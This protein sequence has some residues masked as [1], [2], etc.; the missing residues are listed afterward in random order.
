[1][2]WFFLPPEGRETH[3]IPPIYEHAATMA[4]DTFGDEDA[5]Q[6]YI[7]RILA[8]IGAPRSILHDELLGSAGYPGA[9]EWEA[10]DRKR[11]EL[12][13]TALDQFSYR[14]RRPP[15]HTDRQPHRTAQAGH[16]RR[17][18]PPPAT[19]R[20]RLRPA[21]RPRLAPT[22]SCAPKAFPSTANRPDLAPAT[23]PA[24]G[25]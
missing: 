3:P 9:D 15:R 10:I 12:I 20:R 18:P 13:D 22:A 4:V 24:R 5:W 11:E 19:H 1:M 7:A 25:E 6:W 21:Q 16:R 17:P 2:A 8:L 14:T 23:K